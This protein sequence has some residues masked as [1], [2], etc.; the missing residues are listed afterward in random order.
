MIRW[1]NE[2][3]YERECA[4]EVIDLR[5]RGMMWARTGA[6]VVVWVPEDSGIIRTMT[7]MHVG[8]AYL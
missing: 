1:W 2:G 8:V 6:G 5:P 7:H 4:A 3:R